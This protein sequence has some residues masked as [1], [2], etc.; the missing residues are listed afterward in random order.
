MQTCKCFT[1]HPG[2]SATIK[3]LF[4]FSCISCIHAVLW[5]E[6]ERGRLLP[7]SKNSGPGSSN[8]PCHFLTCSKKYV[9]L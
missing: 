7:I 4:L 1:Y 8:T 5:N 3:I 9:L 6:I 2:I